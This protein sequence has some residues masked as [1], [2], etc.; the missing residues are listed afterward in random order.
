MRK[1]GL[2]LLIVLFISIVIKI[3]LEVMPVNAETNEIVLMDKKDLTLSYYV[4]NE[5]KEANEWKVNYKYQSEKEERRRIKFKILDENNKAIGYPELPNMIENDGW[6]MERDFSEKKEEQI[7]LNLSKSIGQLTLYIQLDKQKASEKENADGEKYIEENTLKQETPFIL[8]SS[9]V[10]ETTKSSVEVSSSEGKSE[11]TSSIHGSF[12]G[13]I[14]EAPQMTATTAAYRSLYGNKIPEYE[15]NESG[16]YPTYSWQPIGQTNVI[17]H[18][19]GIAG[20]LGWDSDSSW[21]ISSDNHTKS[22]IK[23]G[24]DATDP[25][26][27]IRK[28]AQETAKADEFKIKLNVK[29]NTSYKPGVDVVFL[30]DASS[31][32]LNSGSGS[33]LSRKKNTDAALERIITKLK[34]LYPDNQGGIRIGSHIFSDYIGDTEPTSQ[35]SK[36]HSDWDRIVTNYKNAFVVGH[37]FTQR[38]LREAADIFQNAPDIGQRYKLLFV[39]TD[40]APNRSWLP[41][42]IAS[43]PTMYFDKL[44]VSKFDMGIKANYYGYSTFRTGNTT[45]FTSAYNG[46]TSHL[47]T[48]NSTAKVL[49]EVEGI[50][51]HTIGVNI[52]GASGDHPTDQLVKG[53]YRMSTKKAN[54]GESDTASDYFYYDVSNPDELTEVFKNWYDTV[55]RT[56]DKGIIDDPLGD[57][58]DIVEKNAPDSTIK[59]TQVNNGAITIESKDMPTAQLKDGNRTIET[60]N[61]NLTGKQEIEIT[62][63]VKVK[64]AAESGKWYPTNETTILEPTPERT[65]DR[66]EFGSPSVRVLKNDFVIP[67]EKVWRDSHQDEPDYWALRP[68]KVTVALQKQKGETWQNVESIDLDAAHHWKGNFSPVEGGTANTYRVIEPS[69][70][71]GYMQPSIN[72][73][74]FT[75]ETIVSDGIKITN[76]LLRGSYQFWKFMED[77]T[78]KFT[79]DLPKFKVTRSD[80]KVLAENLTP[81]TSGKVAINDFPIGTYT[82]EETHV[83]EGFQKMTDFEIAVTENNNP[84]TSLVF[85]VNGRTDDHHAINRLKDFSIKVEKIDPSDNLLTGAVFKLTGPNGYDETISTGSTF[86]FTGLRPG[87]YSLKEVDN[88]EG[89]QR[90]QEPIAF[91][92]NQD[93]SFTVS[94]H[95]NV[96]DSSGGI[97]TNNTI[98]LKVTNQKVKPGIL[99][100]T[101]YLGIKGFFLIAGIL[102]ATGVTVGSFYYYTSKKEFVK[103]RKK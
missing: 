102:I 69:R 62:Y 80:G 84:P 76:E 32:M 79:G 58:V 92:I 70:T 75:S 29:G 88:P 17:N 64:A 24:E 31:S 99:P 74:S 6:W 11:I 53:L 16:K 54:T 37:T 39:L 30:L 3:A 45:K 85:Q 18:R 19:G 9:K 77:G 83:P 10:E 13:P 103:N 26:I 23:Y 4:V 73:A 49:K 68:D 81:D 41:Q 97:G 98:K 93:G 1:I 27:S 38:G 48:T 78:T 52:A 86:T 33:V 40:G 25:N 91:V 101:G 57:M 87:I 20:E 65:T 63:T 72:Q 22:Y 36:N 34:E 55:I 42:T 5:E 15:D 94:N 82:V 100:S 60:S 90:I 12:I 56:V 21:D 28:Y 44:Y 95:P 50:Q 61:I 2:L 89:Y 51:I 59:I 66:I 43:D 14:V 67:V 96:S 46:L 47:T 71:T 7:V 8:T 35:L